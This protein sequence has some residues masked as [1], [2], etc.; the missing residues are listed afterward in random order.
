M[1]KI[2]WKPR[3]ALPTWIMGRHDNKDLWKQMAVDLS[4][5]QYTGLNQAWKEQRDT[6]DSVNRMYKCT[7]STPWQIWSG[8]WS[9]IE[10]DEIGDMRKGPDTERLITLARRAY[11]LSLKHQR[12]LMSTEMIKHA[13]QDHSGKSLQD[14]LEVTRLVAGKPVWGYWCNWIK[15]I[16]RNRLKAVVS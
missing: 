8:E 4:P 14:R 12:F 11:I 7:E 16:L 6:L 9:G 13:F 3:E 10:G 5:Q 2:T 15:G 1:H